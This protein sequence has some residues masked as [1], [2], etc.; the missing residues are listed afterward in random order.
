[1]GKTFAL[2]HNEGKMPLDSERLKMRVKTVTIALPASLIILGEIL[3]GPFALVT[4]IVDKMSFTSCSLTTMFSSSLLVYGSSSTRT[5]G[6]A[7]RVEISKKVSLKRF[8]F[9]HPL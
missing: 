5:V 9:L 6:G 7:F 8:A 3:S 2:F 4:F 1:M